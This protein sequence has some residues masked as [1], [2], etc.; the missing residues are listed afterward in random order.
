MLEEASSQEFE[1]R[2]AL[3]ELHRDPAE[4]SKYVV[5]ADILLATQLI[6]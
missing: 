4:P 2:R 6:M 3:Q 1:E 5:S